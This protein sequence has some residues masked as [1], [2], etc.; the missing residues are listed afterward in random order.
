VDDAELRA[1][2]MDMHHCVGGYGPKVRGNECIIL[3]K[4]DQTA[5]IQLKLDKTGEVVTSAKIN[6]VKGPYN[7][8]DEPDE[9]L[10]SIATGLV[11]KRIKDIPPELDDDNADGYDDDG[12]PSEQDICD[13]FMKHHIKPLV[14]LIKARPY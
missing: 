12:L 13:I 11:G 4:G 3:T 14:R 6:Q 2:G 5:E 8:V 9:E 10:Q 7:R 1:R